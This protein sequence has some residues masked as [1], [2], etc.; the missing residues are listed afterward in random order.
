MT[1]NTSERKRIVKPY[2]KYKQEAFTSLV[3]AVETVASRVWG[4]GKHVCRKS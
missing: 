1:R 4:N 2:Y 3:K